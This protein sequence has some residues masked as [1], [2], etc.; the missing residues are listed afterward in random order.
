[1][2]ALVTG[3]SSGLG[4]AIATVLAE[5]GCDLLLVSEDGPELKEAGRQI[6]YRSKV[7]VQTLKK[8]LTTLTAADEVFGH[9]RAQG[10]EVDIL[11]NCAGIFTNQERELDDLRR[12]RNLLALHVGT[13]SQ[14]CFLFGKTM[15]QRRRGYIL[16]VGSISALFQDPSSVTYG[17]SKRYVLAFSKSLHSHWREHNVKVTCVVPG[18]IRTAFFRSNNIYLPPIAARHLMP[19]E[20]CAEIAV[21]ALLRGRRL[22]IP[23]VAAKLHALLYRIMLRP[24]FYSL[25]K[26]KYLAMKSRASEQE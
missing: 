13:L 25:L 18:G 11:V 9:C 5:R 6:G 14:L 12:V 3:G 19:V 10:I 23:G 26:R 2:T 20:R 21:R 17:P 7:S 24:A 22:V 1:M 4:R 16:N 15:I 8:D